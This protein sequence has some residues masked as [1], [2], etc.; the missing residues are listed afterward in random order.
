MVG[1]VWILRLITIEYRHLPDRVSFL[2]SMLIFED[3]RRMVVLN[4]LNRTSPLIVNGHCLVERGCTGVWLVDTRKWYDLGA[5]YDSKHELRGY[6]CDI[7]TLA[8]RNPTGYR[9]TDLMLDLCILPDRA[10]VC[11]DQDEFDEAVQSGNL[12]AQLAEKAQ[13]TFVELKNKA[14]ENSF[15]TAQMKELLKLP[16]NVEKIRSELMKARPRGT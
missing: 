14:E 4:M 13:A 5:I 7:T 9:T 12:S 1:E 15:P 11:L 8:E 3:E 6:Y 10:I 2:P 16:E